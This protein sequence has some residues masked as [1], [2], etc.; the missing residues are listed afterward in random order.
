MPYADLEFEKQKLTILIGCIRKPG[1][2]IL[3]VDQ[4][5]PFE[6]ERLIRA[7]HRIQ[8]NLKFRRE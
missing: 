5:V 4:C 8:I 3:L 2:I 1:D 6:N 7:P